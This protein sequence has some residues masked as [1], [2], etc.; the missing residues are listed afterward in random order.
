MVLKNPLNK[1]TVLFARWSF[2]SGIGC[3]KQLPFAFCQPLKQ[4]PPSLARG[5]RKPLCTHLRVCTSIFLPMRGVRFPMG[6][7]SPFFLEVV[8]SQFKSKS[9]PTSLSLVEQLRQSDL[10]HWRDLQTRIDDFTTARLIVDF[11]DQHPSLQAQHMGTYLRARESVQRY[12]I[13]C[14]KRFRAGRLAGTAV[15]NV[16]LLLKVTGK[17]VAFLAVRLASCPQE[18]AMPGKQ[19]GTTNAQEDLVWP[20]LSV[21]NVIRSQIR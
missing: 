20:A 12:R 15:R 8:M 1:V 4:K 5:H 19:T 16:W 21:P 13:R 11:L 17:A 14:A 7:G 9:N 2:I 18:K 3:P 10:A 6:D